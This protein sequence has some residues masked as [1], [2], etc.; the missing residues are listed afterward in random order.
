MNRALFIDHNISLNTPSGTT[1]DTIARLRKAIIEN[2]LMSIWHN[3]ITCDSWIVYESSR[4]KELKLDCEEAKLPLAG[5]SFCFTGAMSISRKEAIDMVESLGG[6]V[7]SSVSKGLTYLVTNDK[8]SGSSKNKK[9]AELGI[10]ILD[11]KEFLKLVN[12]CI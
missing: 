9:A 11:E 5:K 2:N 3:I 6:E 10:A 7:K 8:T 12:T 4:E 1:Q